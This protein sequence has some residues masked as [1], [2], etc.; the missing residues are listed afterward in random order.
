MASSCLCAGGG[1]AMRKRPLE[2]ERERGEQDCREP[3][4]R[5][6][7]R[8]MREMENERRDTE[9]K[10]TSLSHRRKGSCLLLPFS[11]LLK[12]VSRH[13]F[14]W[15]YCS[16][17]FYLAKQQFTTRV[18][19]SSPES[20]G[21]TASLRENLS[22]SA[23]ICVERGRRG[24]EEED[25]DDARAEENKKEPTPKE[26]GGGSRNERRFG[27]VG[28]AYTRMY[29]GGLRYEEKKGKKAGESPLELK[30]EK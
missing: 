1:E 21:W 27:D 18:T 16:T 4:L 12:H 24:Q 6:R 10:K 28:S 25:C 2:R 8:D 13:F 19:R 5:L 22:P 3:C 11:R 15:P 30:N 9:G 20:N 29:R 26:M 23:G 14:V 17:S 7:R